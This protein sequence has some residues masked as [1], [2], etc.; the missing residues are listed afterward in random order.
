MAIVGVGLAIATTNW[1]VNFDTSAIILRVLNAR[2][3]FFTAG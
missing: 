1:L 3:I 2:I